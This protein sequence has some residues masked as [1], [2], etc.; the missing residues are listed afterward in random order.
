MI[1]M[2]N[3]YRGRCP[4]ATE[5]DTLGGLSSALELGTLDL[6]W[7][8]TILP[9]IMPGRL[10]ASPVVTIRSPSYALR[11]QRGKNIGGRPSFMIVLSDS[12]HS[13]VE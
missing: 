2:R 7:R 10:G 12:D 8:E 13:Y 1:I 9:Q 3:Q 4:N 11:A 5:R 6:V